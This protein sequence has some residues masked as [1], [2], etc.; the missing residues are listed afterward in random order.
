MQLT[1]CARR[2]LVWMLPLHRANG[3]RGKLAEGPERRAGTKPLLAQPRDKLKCFAVWTTRRSH[4]DDGVADA[5]CLL[6]E[7]T[8]F[9]GLVHY[10]I[11]HFFQVHVAGICREEKHGQDPAPFVSCLLWGTWKATK[12]GAGPA[13]TMLSATKPHVHSHIKSHSPSR[14]LATF[15]I[16]S[17]TV[18]SP[19]RLET[20]PSRWEN[21]GGKQII[22]EARS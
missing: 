14:T 5:P 3:R 9:E 7:H 4:L 20:Q 17:P 15:E 16:P 21:D 2:L 22:R 18:H 11:G 13:T 19:P 1:A 10:N 6:A 8:V 12:V